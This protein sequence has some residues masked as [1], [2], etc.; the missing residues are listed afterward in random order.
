[1]LAEDVVRAQKAIDSGLLD[2]GASGAGLPGGASSAPS[3]QYFTYDSEA[4]VA[5]TRDVW[6]W[7]KNTL[8]VFFLLI[9]ATQVFFMYIVAQ[10]QI[11]VI[12]KGTSAIAN[13]LERAK[14]AASVLVQLCFNVLMLP[15]L[16]FIPESVEQRMKEQLKEGWRKRER[17]PLGLIWLLTVQFCR[18]LSQS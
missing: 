17:T 2:F 3:V 8:I 7:N 18:S 6:C 13:F 9:L 14:D 15:A 10:F 1:M 16:P 5:L 4:K 12:E 11:T